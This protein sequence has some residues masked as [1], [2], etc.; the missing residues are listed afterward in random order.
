MEDVVIRRNIT[1]MVDSDIMKAM[2]ITEQI[3]S[4]MGFLPRECLFLRLATEEACMNAYEYCQKTNQ[5]PF[6][7]F[8]TCEKEK[9]MIVVKQHGKKF[10]IT[11]RDV[12]NKGLRGRGLQLIIHIVDHVYLEQK[13]NNVLF[14]MCKYKDH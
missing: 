5:L 2:D 3:A 4:E 6:E 13:G 12:V 14:Y 1:V 11:R 9:L 7:V 10:D 8:W